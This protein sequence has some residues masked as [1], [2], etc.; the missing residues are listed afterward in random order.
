MMDKITVFEEMTWGNIPHII[1]ISYKWYSI[2]IPPSN[3][4]VTEE[5]SYTST[6]PLGNSGPVTGLLYYGTV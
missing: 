4:E 5:Y 2:R 1:H 6:H 3:A